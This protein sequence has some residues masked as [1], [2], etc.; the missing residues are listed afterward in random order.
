MVAP[1]AGSVDWNCQMIEIS[2]VNPRRSLCGERGLKF[3]RCE[4]ARN[5]ALVAP[6]AGSVDWNFPSPYQPKFIIVA[7]FAGSVDWNMIDNNSAASSNS[8]SLCGERGLKYQLPPVIAFCKMSLPLRG[9]WIEI[10]HLL[11]VNLL[12]FVAPFAGSVDWNNEFETFIK[13]FRIESMMW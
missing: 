2:S 4:N 6:F 11:R 12:K 5:K 8:R 9:A 13:F 1:F 7:P 10:T 3:K